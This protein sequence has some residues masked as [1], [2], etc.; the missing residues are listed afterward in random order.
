MAFSIK[1]EEADRLARQLAAITGES[2]TEA[3]IRS[4]SE[5][6]R[7]HQLPTRSKRAG[8]QLARMAKTLRKLPVLDARSADDILGYDEN[9]LPN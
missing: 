2:L 5:R 6:L 8:T 4:L 3:V 7:R 1:N 9:G